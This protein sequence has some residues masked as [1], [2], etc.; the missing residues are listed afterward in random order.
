[1]P[2]FM[3]IYDRVKRE[4]PMR[5]GAEKSHAHGLNIVL[6]TSGRSTQRTMHMTAAQEP[7]RICNAFM[8]KPSKPV[9]IYDQGKTV[10]HCVT[11]TNIQI[12][13]RNT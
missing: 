2:T 8:A 7:P 9:Y 11:I 4:G 5:G 13:R 12:L 10:F 6:E 3:G 1:M